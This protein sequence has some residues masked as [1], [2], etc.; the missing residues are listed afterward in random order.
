MKTLKESVD[1]LNALIREF[2]FHEA[3]DKFYDESIVTHE[4]ENPPIVGLSAY[5][6]AAKNYLDSISNEK[7]ELINVIISDTMSVTEWRYRFDHKTWGKWD[8]IQIS[9]QRWKDGKI[10][11]ERHHYKT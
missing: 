3:L 11:H 1:E 2:K 9:V 6:E 5:R 4:N 8:A 10:V 7:A